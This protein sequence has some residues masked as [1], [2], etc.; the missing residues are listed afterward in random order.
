MVARTKTKAAAQ[1]QKTSTTL[2]SVRVQ[3]VL[4]Y[5]LTLCSVEGRRSREGAQSL[6]G[7]CRR[8]EGEGRLARLASSSSVL[9]ITHTSRRGFKALK[10]STKLL[11]LRLHRPQDALATYNQLLTY[12]KSAVTRNYSE[13]SINGILDYVGGASKTGAIKTSVDLDILE[14][15]YEATRSA[16]EESKN[17]VRS[18]LA[19]IGATP[20][21]CISYSAC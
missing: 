2:R 12:T 3:R 11:Y 5:C 1:T 10:Q 4:S 16:L 17:D 14:K 8:R 13:K 18:C 21:M 20:L 15:F 6:Q 19:R 9:H 7:H